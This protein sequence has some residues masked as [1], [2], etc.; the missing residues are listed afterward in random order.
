MPAMLWASPAGPH[1]SKPQERPPV[2][3]RR[4]KC[5]T[6]KNNNKT[7]QMGSNKVIMKEEICK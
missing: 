5:P 7:Y 1:R 6:N 2:G 4:M 3:V